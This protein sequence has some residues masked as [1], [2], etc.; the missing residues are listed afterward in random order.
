MPTS[1]TPAVQP[2]HRSSSRDPETSTPLP[3]W[4]LSSRSSSGVAPVERTTDGT[5]S[6]E[7]R[8]A[9]GGAVVL[10][11]R[12][13]PLPRYR[14]KM[15][16]KLSTTTAIMARVRKDRQFRRPTRR[17]LG[18]IGFMCHSF[19]SERFSGH[20]IQMHRNTEVSYLVN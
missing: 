17:R 10:V 7:V 6:A 19:V 2:S 12:L 1:G 14:E 5:E 3:M 20:I 8:T 4:N 16:T 18:R 15:K 9:D 11:T 13:L